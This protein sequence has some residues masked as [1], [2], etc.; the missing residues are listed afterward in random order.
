MTSLFKATQATRYD[1]TF[2][3]HHHRLANCDA[4][5]RLI[6]DTTLT[7]LFSG[8]ACFARYQMTQLNKSSAM[9]VNMVAMYQS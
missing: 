7:L 3:I 6:G 2:I 1:A 4:V 9:I 8:A 5:V